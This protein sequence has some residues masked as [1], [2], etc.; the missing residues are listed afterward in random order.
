MIDWLL[1]VLVRTTGWLLC[2]LPPAV[3]VGMG[4]ALGELAY[5]VQ[6]KR[7][8]IGCLNLKAAFGDRLTP[9]QR[10]RVI[11]GVFGQLGAGLVEMLRLPAVDAAYL[12]RYITVE[13]QSR[14]LAAVNA[15]QPVILLTGHF[16]NWELMSI[17]AAL[18][19][20]PIVVLAREQ[21]NLPNLYRLLGSYRELKGCRV[22]HKG[23]AMRQLL[24]ALGRGEPVGFVGDQVSRRGIAVDFFGRP[25]LFAT[26]PFA[27]A[28]ASGALLVPAFI[29]RIRG[30]FHRVVVEPPIPIM[31][32]PNAEASL[33]SGIEQFAAILQRHI[34]QDPSQWLWLH[35]RWKHTPERRVLVLSD[36][37]LGHLKQ[38]LTVLQAI[39]EQAP[40]VREQVVEVRYRSRMGRALALA[41]ASLVPGGL[42]G[43]RCLQWALEPG[44]A[45]RL[46]STYA[47]V[48][49]SCGSAT[50]AV[51]ALVSAD[52]RAKSVIIMNP[53]PIAVRKFDLAFIPVHDRVRSHPNVVRTYGALTAVSD[54]QMAEARERLRRHPKFQASATLSN[55]RVGVAVLIGGDT[56]QYRLT[57]AF[58]EALVRQV[59]AVC[60]EVGAFCMVTTS[61]RTSP[62]VERVLIERLAKSPRCSLLLLASRDPLDGTVEGM[63]G[64]AQVAVVTG[65]SISMVSEACSSGRHI[66]VVEPPLR[67]APSGD[68]KPQ[69]YLRAMAEQ[70]YLRRHPLPEVGHA[71]RQVLAHRPPARRLD[72]YATI[73]AA[74]K[75]LL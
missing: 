69:R 6:P 21:G 37:K 2:R 15:K 47:D 34:E 54:A 74:V 71:I 33:R 66:V 3:V 32:G 49:I 56:A 40:S 5:W 58:I 20:A 42:G 57:T 73:Q 53:S 19:G 12:Q 46:V 36:G 1:C 11:H 51:N 55:G 45:K 16:G 65:E 29:H 28:Q 9:A 75:R 17:V 18:I 44:C 24:R 43:L 8:R 35:K 63:L 13:G 22:A 41:W 26:G 14:F 30:P 62:E 67:H 4:T 10:R 68:T 27:L 60:E 52:N 72:T 38:S 25:A 48:V 61:R 23:G 50:V 59:L 70:G 31:K 64:L 39:K 7:V